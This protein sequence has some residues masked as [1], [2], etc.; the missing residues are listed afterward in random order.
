LK[1]LIIKTALITLIAI[2]GVASV[3]LGCLMIFAPK[4]S[5]KMFDGLGMERVAFSF[6][7]KQYEKSQELTDLAILIDKINAEDEPTKTEKL[8]LEFIENEGFEDFVKLKGK[9]NFGSETKAKEFYYGKLVVAEVTLGK[10]T[11]ALDNAYDFYRLCGGYTEGNPYRMILYEKG[12][13][14][15]EAELNKLK[16]QIRIRKNEDNETRVNQDVAEIEKII[17][18]KK[19]LLEEGE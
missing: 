5:A 13:D 2:I 15:T 17:E 11:D 18:E 12:E 16:T 3:V 8:C 19:T 7:E 6:Y 14:L 9:K 4:T 1:K 10:L